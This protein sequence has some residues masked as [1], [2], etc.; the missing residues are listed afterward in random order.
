MHEAV[1]PGA[2]DAGLV[3]PIRIDGVFDDPGVIRRLVQRNGPYRMM[4]SYLPASAV[5]DGQP[6]AAGGVPAHFRATW[7]AGGRPLVDGTEVILYNPSL[8]RAASQLLDTEV[9]PNTV[10]VNVTAPM[11]AGNI[12][13]DVPSFL[14]ADRDRYPMQLLQA[15]AASGLFEDCES[16]KQASCGGTTK[17]PAARTTTGRTGSTVRC[18]PSTRRFSTPPWSPTTTACTTGSAGS[19][20]PPPLLR[21]FPPPPRSAI[22]PTVAGPSATPAE[23]RPLRRP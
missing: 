10:A 1:V 23:P 18:A 22:T 7:A 11:L 12:H 6:A 8:L 3:S 20:I 14:G 17:G 13:V 5:R 15:M 21:P 16:P 19:A 4:V 2:G 9:V